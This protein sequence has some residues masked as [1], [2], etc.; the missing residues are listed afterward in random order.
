MATRRRFIGAAAAGAALVTAPAIIRRAGAAV[1]LT[2]STP[3]GFD[4]T[5]IDIYNAVAGGH[6]ARQGLD[7]KVVG[8]PGNAAAFQLMLAGEAQFTYIASVDFIRAVATRGAPF[9]G[10]ATIAQ[11]IGFAIVSLAEK[12]VR[13]GADLGGKTVGVL[14]VGGLSE[15]LI[16][17]ALAKAGLPKS[18]ANIVV[19]GNSPG[20]VELIRKGRIDCFICNYPLVI[21]LQRMNLPLHYLDIDGV[22]AAPGLLYFCTRDTMEKRADLIP[23]FLRAVKGSVLEILSQPLQP[24]FERA[25]KTFEITRSNDMAALVAVQQAVNRHQWLVDGRQNLL[26]NEPRLWQSACDALRAI[27]VADVKDPAALYTN[28][29]IDQ[30]MKA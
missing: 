19:A 18:A 12:P 13:S 3:Y 2:F 9:I 1:P 17:V 10:I 11:R 20:E 27:G 28:Q 23:P 29:F 25:A 14:S 8:P 15:L 16:Q 26:R 30:V 7:V 21:T 4:A 22:I 5:F 24:I 6:F